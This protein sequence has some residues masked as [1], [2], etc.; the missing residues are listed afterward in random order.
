M[1]SHQFK[2][3]APAARWSK[4][5]HD[6]GPRPHICPHMLDVVPKTAAATLQCTCA[7]LILALHI[8]GAS[9]PWPYAQVGAMPLVRP[10]KHKNESNVLSSTDFKHQMASAGW[11]KLLGSRL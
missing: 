6:I 9:M 10:C 3:Q 1:R 7:E 11:A 8:V 4:A 5:L 2:Q